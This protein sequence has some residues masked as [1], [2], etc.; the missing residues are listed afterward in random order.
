MRTRLL[1]DT[2]VVVRWLADPKKLS[3]SQLRTLDAAVRRAEPVALSAISLLE[4]A[5]LT[6]DGRL[7]LKTA[8]DELLVDLQANPLF[9]VLPLDYETASEV[10]SLGRSLR[11]PADRAIVA[12]ARVHRL[13]LV[14]SDQRIIESNLVPVIE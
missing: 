5:V 10:V 6:A 1:L 4:I 2:H 3:R 12:T 7:R 9:Q 8:L 13:R 14:T 11:D